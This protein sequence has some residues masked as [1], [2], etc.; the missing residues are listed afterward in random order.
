[1]SSQI[2]EV[3]RRPYAEAAQTVTW[4]DIAATVPGLEETRP[5]RRPRTIPALAAAATVVVAIVVALVPALLAHGPAQSPA[6]RLPFGHRAL[7]GRQAPAGFF[8]ALPASGAVQ[9]RSAVTGRLIAAVT[10]PA[11]GEFF[12]GVA[13]TGAGGRTLL[14]AVEH[15]IGSPCRTWVFQLQLTAAGQPGALK[16]AAIPS[17][18]WIL[19]N[20][21]LPRHPMDPRLP[22]PVTAGGATPWRLTVRTRASRPAWPAAAA[23]RLT[24]SR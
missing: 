17:I 10:P 23:T 24:T 5:A 8:A 22:S 15:D 21:A 14:L 19:P 20:R 18:R 11:R 6:G 16:P 4:A 3:L 1:V 13:A 2:E 7:P 9:I 12:S